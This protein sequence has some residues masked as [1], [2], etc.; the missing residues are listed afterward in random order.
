MITDLFADLWDFVFNLYRKIQL[1]YYWSICRPLRLCLPLTISSIPTFFDFRVRVMATRF[2]LTGG[3]ADLRWALYGTTIPSVLILYA[4]A[5]PPPN[6][7]DSEMSWTQFGRGQVSEHTGWYRTSFPSSS[8]E[9]GMV[10]RR[11]Y[12]PPPSPRWLVLLCKIVNRKQ[13]LWTSSRV[14]ALQ[15]C[16]VECPVAFFISSLQS[17]ID[18]LILFFQLFWHNF[19]DHCCTCQWWW[20]GG[21]GGRGCLRLTQDLEKSGQMLGYTLSRQMGTLSGWSKEQ[22]VTTTMPVLSSSQH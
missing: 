13:I 14:G 10:K 8:G 21:G 15:C 18:G 7:D 9:E 3:M 16:G 20:A 4:D 22:S 17:G 11:N 2:L 6:K 1:F 19:V 12:L 5:R